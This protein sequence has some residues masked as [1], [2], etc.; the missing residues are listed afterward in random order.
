MGQSSEYSDLKWVAPKSWTNA[1]RSSVQLIVIHT[2]QG[3]YHGQSAEDGA[4]YDARRT[5]GVSTHYFH[6]DNSTVQCVRTEDVAHHARS[7]GNKRGIGHE[8]CG[9]AEWDNEWSNSYATAMLKRAAKQAARDAHKWEIPVKHLTVAQ[10]D[11]GNKGF[12]GHNDVTKA[13]PEDGG[14]HTD[15]GPD[16]PWSTFLDMV[17][18]E[19]EDIDMPSVEEIW[20]YLLEDP[21]DD[22]NPPRKLSAGSWLR[23]VPSDG[24]VAAVKS[25]VKAVGQDVD[26]LGVQ[27]KGLQAEVAKQ[28]SIL[29]AQSGDIAQI[30]ALLTPPP[31]P[32]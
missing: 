10:V 25:E 31:P 24:D 17:R 8:L 18:D 21:Y 4:A 11:A 20:A 14:T 30:L 27:V 13:F 23:Y 29:A 1:N 16:F 2:T 7:Q 5:D 22:S 6:D 9:R 26:S 12:C 19:L 28:S 15:P 32:A 3:S